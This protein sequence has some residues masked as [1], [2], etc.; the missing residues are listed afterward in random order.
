[1]TRRGWRE[2]LAIVAWLLTIGPPVAG[3]TEG[4]LGLGASVIEYDGFLSSGAVV[5]APALR[6][7]SPRLSFGGQGSWTMFE[8]GRSVIQGTAAV[9]WLAGSSRAWRLELSGSAGASEYAAESVTGHLLAG[10]R[11]HVFAAGTGGWLGANLGQSFGGPS[12]VPMELVVAGWSV[13]NRVALVGSATTTFQGRLRQLDLVGAIRWTGPKLELEVRAGARP[14]AHDPENASGGF[15]EAFGEI[16]MTVPLSPRLAVSLGGGKYPS[17]PVR[18]VV[19]ARYLSAGFR[20]RTFG[21]QARSVP[22]HTT[23]VLRSRLVPTDENGPPL[24]IGGPAE[25]RTLRIRAGDATSVEL[26]GD[27]TDWIPVR[28]TRVAPAVWEIKLAIPAGVHRVN[29]RLN[30]GVWSVPGGARLERTEFG[31]SVGIVVVP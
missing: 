30:G 5:F 8:S 6:F 12:G 21:R 1:M 13:S 27:F 22:V 17:D 24:E 23:G 19:G 3:Q 7:D 14:W 4:T 11:L 15:T 9:A 2:A 28:L 29:I 20:L 25:R 16:T 31:G 26:M 10:A 18:Q